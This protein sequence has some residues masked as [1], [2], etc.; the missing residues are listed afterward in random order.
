MLKPVDKEKAKQAVSQ[1]FEKKKKT[2]QE[3]QQSAPVDGD[4]ASGPATTEP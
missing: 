1:Y 2:E 4:P 3:G